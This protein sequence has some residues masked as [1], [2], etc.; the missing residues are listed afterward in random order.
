[1]NDRIILIP[2]ICPTNRCLFWQGRT[3]AFWESDVTYY[4]YVVVGDGLVKCPVCGVVYDTTGA[5]APEQPGDDMPDNVIVNPTFQPPYAPQDGVG[6]LQVAQ[7]WR[8]GWDNARK[9]P[10]WRRSAA[11][12]EYSQQWFC[13]SN[14]MDAWISQRVNVGA[15]SIGKYA[16]L[17]VTCALESKNTGS[18]IG[19]YFLSIGIDRTGDENVSAKTVEWLTPKHQS[20]VPKWTTFE[21]LAKIEKE[22]VTVY[23]QADNRWPVNGSIFVKSATLM[24]IDDPCGT[25][26]PEPQPEPTVPGECGFDD[27]SILLAIEGTKQAILNRLNS[28]TLKVG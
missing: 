17:V 27:T 8:C 28:L 19:D 22:Y 18:G 14:V 13:T 5:A 12:W 21:L 11:D 4:P 6:E 23:I 20:G 25:P 24:I 15:S 26:Q 16:K 10:E 7:G 2:Q 3:I 1:M 9:R